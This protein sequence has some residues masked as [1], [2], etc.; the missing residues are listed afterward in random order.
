MDHRA[1]F[2][3]LL[4]ELSNAKREL[5]RIENEI[6]DLV[7]RDADRQGLPYELRLQ[8]FLQSVI[9]DEADPAASS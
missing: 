8:Q 2:R 5:W 4:S 1:E 9:D 7:G 6:K 3:R